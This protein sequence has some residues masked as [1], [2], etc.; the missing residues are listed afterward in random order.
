VMISLLILLVLTFAAWEL[1]VFYRRRASLP[2]G[3]FAVPLLGNLINE[4]KLP[5]IHD[6]LKRLSARFGPIVTVYLPMP[7]VNI[8]DF[9]TMKKAFKGND[10]TGRMQN[11]LVEVTRMCENGGIISSDGA[12]WQEQRRF[13]ITTLREFGMGK[14]LLE[15]KVRL[16]A[17]N[18]V[19]FI[20]K[21][22]LQNTDLRLPIQLFVSN[23]I[24]ELLY[25]FQY[26]FDDCEK[27]MYFVLGLSEAITNVSESK[28]VAIIFMLPWTR[29]LPIISYFWGKHVKQFQKMTDHVRELCDAVK[30]DPNEEPTCFVQAF[31]KNSKDKRVEQLLSSCSDLFIAGQETTTTT[32]RWGMLL[33]AAHPEIQEKL[34]AEIHAEIGEDRVASMSDKTK[35]PYASA[36]VMEI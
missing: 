32:L 34:R 8:V 35:M 4:I 26:P 9:E 30:Y 7:V 24:N 23:I 28:L 33:L 6:G 31:R 18:M 36:V 13:A 12:D 16:S 22:D 29:H 11:P 17:R 20:K 21:Q 27:L 15:E 3:P 10:I 25:G 19:D 2:P 14:N 1:L 5:Y